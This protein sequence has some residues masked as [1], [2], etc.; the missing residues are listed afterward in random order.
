MN[1]ILTGQYDLLY[2][3]PGPCRYPQNGSRT[4]FCLVDNV[5]VKVKVKVIDEN[6]K[7]LVIN[8]EISIKCVLVHTFY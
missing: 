6:T 3:I 4:I 1:V 5:K 8:E 2:L 7:Y